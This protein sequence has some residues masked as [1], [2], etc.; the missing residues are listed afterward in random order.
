MW[1]EWT[2][3]TLQSNEVKFP[4]PTIKTWC[5]LP[6]FVDES[7]R[8]NMELRTLA[9]HYIKAY[10]FQIKEDNP[11]IA[12]F[13]EIIRICREKGITVVLNLLAENVE[14]A[15]ELLGDP[16]VYLMRKNRDFLKNR[17]EGEGVYVVD[18]LEKVSNKHFTDQNWTTEHYDQVGRQ[19]IADQVADLLSRL[20]KGGDVTTE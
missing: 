18:N 2:F 1:Y 7:G 13:D 9:D 20:K 4:A 5:A 3:D 6:K 12:Q 14:R 8:Q 17:F 15:E 11:R 10:A 16:L 19:I